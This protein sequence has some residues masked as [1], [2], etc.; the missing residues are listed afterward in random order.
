M[1]TRKYFPQYKADIFTKNITVHFSRCF[2][3]A[4]DSMS[5]SYRT[6]WMAEDDFIIRIYKIA[7]E[8]STETKD[9]VVITKHTQ[10]IVESDE[11]N[12]YS[13]DAA[14]AIWKIAKQTDNYDEVVAA[15]KYI[16][17]IEHDKVQEVR[18]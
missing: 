7:H 16:E 14:N 17:K 9:E 5:D 13:K 12:V 6:S 15:A 1:P 18:V 8:Y 11:F 2:V 3:D 4:T 10:K